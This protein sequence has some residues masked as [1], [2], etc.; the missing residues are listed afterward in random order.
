MSYSPGFFFENHPDPMLVYDPA[1]L[2]ILDVNRAAVAVYGFSHDEFLNLTVTAIRPPEDIARVATFIKNLDPAQRSSG[3]L[4]RHL[5][6]DGRIVYVNI[7]S[8][9]MVFNGINARVV[10]VHDVTETAKLLGYTHTA[11]I[12][13]HSTESGNE[14]QQ[15]LSKYEANLR[16]AQRLLGLGF[17]SLN[18]E[19]LELVWSDN[20]YPMYGLERSAFGHTAN[21]YFACDHPDDRQAFE[22]AFE[23][24]LIN[25]TPTFDILHRILRPDGRVIHIRGVGELSLTPSGRVLNGVVQDT[26]DQHEVAERLHQAHKMEAVGQL[27]GGVA[28]DF[29]NLLTV[30]MGNAEL[31]KE[32]L[33]EHP[34]LRVFADMTSKA[35]ERGAE[36]TNRLLA[37]ARRQPLQ[38]DVINTNKL[39]AGI[40]GLL[41]RALTEDIDIELV[42]GGGV[43]PIEVDAGQLESAVLNLAINAR[44]AMPDGGKL[45]V[46]TANAHLD[47]AYAQQ[48]HEVEPGQYVMISVSDTGTGM[49]PDIVS[50]AFDPFYTTKP[51]G[52]GSGLGL[53]MVYGFVKQSGGHIK[54]Y[55]ESG[56][57]TTIRMYF[58]RANTPGQAW[59]SP[60]APSL[61]LVG[62]EHILVVEDDELV[63]SHVVSQLAGLGY[64]VTEASSGPAALHILSQGTDIDLLFTDVVM[65]GGVNGRQ[66][67]EQ[68]MAL[69]PG[70][71]VLYTSGYTENAIVHHGRLDRGVHLLT[72]PYRRHELAAK[73]R[74]V[75]EDR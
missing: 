70:L 20:I 68:A 71:K 57:G 56:E 49:A 66:L 4:W 62:T 72:K 33:D 24:F 53:S 22:Q 74:K 39:V 43:W 2:R 11:E 26:T 75:L 46:E 31:L 8:E 21:D 60:A 14:Q 27:T 54:I 65:P 58:P 18:L 67:A 28:H 19:T 37:F 35:A 69:C 64:R 44:D 50:R 47:D 23:R 9:P 13:G 55:S 61:A 12:A 52:K 36:L 17:W 38:P 10:V 45:T 30:I 25:P 29:N 3:K 7:I 59:A 32:S 5:T 63:R 34:N 73:V 40:E 15:R 48:H 16:M 42:R 6:K 41:R 1:T 51:V